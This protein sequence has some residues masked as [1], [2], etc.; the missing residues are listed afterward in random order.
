M[1]GQIKSHLGYKRA[2]GQ[3]GTQQQQ[4][5]QQQQHKRNQL[6]PK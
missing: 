6:K 5:Q 3:L 4:Q 2:Q 1:K